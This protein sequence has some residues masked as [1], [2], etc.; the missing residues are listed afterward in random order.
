MSLVNI[1]GRHVRTSKINP[2]P[3]RASISRNSTRAECGR[4][5]LMV[6]LAGICPHAMRMHL[7]TA[8][9]QSANARELIAA[10]DH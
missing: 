4:S 7:L 3:M 6:W 2:K 10:F 5:Q 8:R 9:I 1:A